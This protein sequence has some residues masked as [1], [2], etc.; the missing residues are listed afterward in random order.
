MSKYQCKCGGLI[1]PEFEAFKVG[2]DVNFMQQKVE[3]FAGGLVS[4]EQKAYTGLI[5]K[6]KGDDI[7]VKSGNKLYD[8]Y[9]F[10]ITPIDAPGPIEYHRIGKCRCELDQEQSA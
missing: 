1:L 10:E 9:R 6:I 5:T 8:L 3:Q 7:Q 2:D 4:L